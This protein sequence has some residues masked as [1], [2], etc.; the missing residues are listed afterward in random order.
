[1]IIK[2]YKTYCYTFYYK[3]AWAVGKYCILPAG[4]NKLG[5][6]T[7]GSVAVS[8]V[9]Q[10]LR[11]GRGVKIARSQATPGDIWADA[12]QGNLHIGIVW[13]ADGS[14]AKTILSNSSSKAKFSWI[15][16]VASVNRYYGGGEGQYYRVTS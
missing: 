4:L 1:M 7:Y 16:S 13:E 14:G 5:A 3:C 2:T 8:G 11:D 10:A 15:G 6:G 12:P 9:L